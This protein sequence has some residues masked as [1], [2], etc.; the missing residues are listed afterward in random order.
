MLKKTHFDFIIAGGGLQGC[1]LA[2]GICRQQ[3]RANVLLVEKQPNLCGNHTWSFHRSDINASTWSWMEPLVDRYWQGYHVQLGGIRKEIPIGYGSIFAESLAAK[4]QQLRDVTAGFSIHQEFVTQLTP[5]R[6]TLGSG[7]MAE[8]ACVLDCRGL[9]RAESQHRNMGFQKFFGLEV[10]LESDWHDSMPC[11]MDDQV[12]QADGFRFMYTLP[13]SK[14]RVLVEDTRFSNTPDLQPM[15]CQT[16]IHDYLQQRGHTQYQIIRHE[17]GCLPMPYQRHQPVGEMAVGYRGGFFHPATGYS[18]PMV[19][20]LADQIAG[21]PARQAPEVIQAFRRSRKFQTHF[22]LWLN[23]L[24]FHLVK[25]SQRHTV[26]KRFY[27]HLPL[28]TIQRF[29]SCQFTAT[30]AARMFLGRPPRGLTPIHFVRSFREQPCPAF[31]N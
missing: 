9:Q 14:R 1:L 10:E 19:A 29:Y 24:L 18:I 3:P 15:A 6:V 27:E 13:F 4:I 12:D 8:G 16:L 21:K 11:L 17:S 31:Q 23:R 22:S 7:E 28:S 30:D 20:D 2:Y 25:P 26:F 5:N